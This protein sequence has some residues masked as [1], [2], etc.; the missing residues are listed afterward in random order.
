MKRTLLTVISVCLVLASLFGIYAAGTGMG[1]VSGILRFKN[2]QKADIAE[3]V[4]ILDDCAKELDAMDEDRADDELQY[5]KDVVTEKEGS[6]QLNQGQAQYN[7]G[8]AQLQQGQAEYDKGLAQYNSGKSAYDAAEAEYNQKLAEYNAAEKKLTDADAQLAEAKNERDAA[9][10]KLDAA[11]PAYN[12]AKPLYDQVQKVPVLEATLNGVL[13]QFGYSSMGQLI[14]DY[15]SG[16]AQLAEANAQIDEAERQISEGKVQLANAKVQLENGKKQLDAA[17]AELANGKAELDKGKAELDKGKAELAKA[18]NQLTA[19]QQVLNETTD[20]MNDLKDSLKESDDARSAMSEGV[21]LLMDIDGIADKVTDESD[22]HAVLDA[23][24]EYLDEDSASVLAEL[25]LRQTLYKLLRIVSIIG[26]LAGVVGIAAAFRPSTALLTAA[27]AAEGLT[28]VGAAAVN[29]YGAV[30]GYSSFVYALEDGSG[31]GSTQMAALI[32]L[33][34]VAVL[35]AIIAAVCLKSY[36][37]ALNGEA[38]E[39]ELTEEEDDYTK[40]VAEAPVEPI[41]E[42]PTAEIPVEPVIVPAQEATVKEAKPDADERMKEFE[43]A[44]S[45]YEEALRRFEEARRRA[46]N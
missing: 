7:A 45:E 24:R 10:A 1:D 14:S 27:V 17:K 19:G 31:S 8:A 4:D 2:N 29:I 23:A 11:T 41:E 44:R 28:A 13:S 12:A 5:A 42:T 21:K 6:T 37:T 40:P 30:K 22:Y 34:V 25:N 43:D 38:D 9:Q 15:E 3:F 32:V 26:V 39:E 46:G 18:K 20:E 36:K 33:L 35:A 16:K